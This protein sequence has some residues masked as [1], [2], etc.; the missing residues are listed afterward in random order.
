MC[1]RIDELMVVVDLEKVARK[2]SVL[3]VDGRAVT[4][5]SAV[6]RLRR[7]S[8]CRITQ[9]K[10]SQRSWPRASKTV[11]AILPQKRRASKG[12]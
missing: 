4:A 10:A 9:E 5:Q 8:K 6:T 2:I 7:G 3:L 12:F 1:R 11:H